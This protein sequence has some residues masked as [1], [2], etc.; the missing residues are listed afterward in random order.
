MGNKPHVSANDNLNSLPK[1]QREVAN[2]ISLWWLG[3][4]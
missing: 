2:M 4:S 3:T 1:S